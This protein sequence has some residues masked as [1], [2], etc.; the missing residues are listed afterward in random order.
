MAAA[1]WKKS[2]SMSRAV[3]AAKPGGPRKEPPP[4]LRG[5]IVGTPHLGNDAAPLVPVALVLAAPARSDLLADGANG[6]L[7]IPAI[8]HRPQCRLFRARRRHFHR[9]GAAVGHSVP[10]PAWLL[11]FVPGGNV[12]A[13]PRQH[14][15]EP[16][17]PVRV[18]HPADGDQ[19]G[20]AVAWRGAGDI[21]P[22]RVFL[23]S[24]LPLSP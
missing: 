18:H 24:P 1:H 14:H 8:L 6:D 12:F 23:F 20:A 17:A 5:R 19:R 21:S 3:T 11:D 15:D 7:G 16:A 2:F 9:R 4:L 13:Q 10:G 22:P